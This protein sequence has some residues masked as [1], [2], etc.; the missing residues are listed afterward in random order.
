MSVVGQ[1]AKSPRSDRMSASPP[2]PDM[3]RVYEYRALITQRRSRARDQPK[4]RNARA[5][6][7]LQYLVALLAYKVV[8]NAENNPRFASLINRAAMAGHNAG[9][10]R[11]YIR[12]RCWSMHDWCFSSS[13]SLEQALLFMLQ[14]VATSWEAR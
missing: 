1:K 14:S 8:A 10:L 4:H 13:G 7:R 2:K 3:A 11:D 12:E 9:H 6:P 5:A